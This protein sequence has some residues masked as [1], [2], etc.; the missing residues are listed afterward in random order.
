MRT[1]RLAAIAA[2]LLTIVACKPKEEAPLQVEPVSVT[3]EIAS[4][5]T[6]YLN[7]TYVGTIEE[8][9]S[10][11]VSF[12]GIGQVTRVC[13][14]EGQRVKKGQVIAEMDAAQ[15]KNMLATAEA[16]MAQ[17]NDALDRMKKLH[18]SGSLPDIKWVEVQ[19]QV[20][21]AKSQL[22]MAKKNVEDCRIYA[23]VSGI[24]S[25]KI[26]E[27]GMT[28]VTSQ[29]IVN[30]LDIS[31]VKVRVAIPE[32]EIAAIKADT[33]TIVSIEA[34]GR[35]MEGGHV[36]KCI[37]ADA[38]T[39]TYD[40]KITLPNGSGELLP[41]MIASVKIQG[42]SAK[43]VVSA[44]TLPVRCVQQS[45]DGSHFVW[46]EKGGKAHRQTVAIG[47]TYGN[48]IVITSGLNGGE[49]IITEGYQ[50]VG[51]GSAVKV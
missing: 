16:Q 20:A 30:I 31:S 44:I 4:S 3:T 15:A 38:T 24:I 2:S 22:D 29:P 34:I 45:S 48:R 43:D 46:I 17:A 19:S 42:S 13:V 36:E 1:I 12:T 11:P 18:D 14:Q 40:I 47:E 25:S 8:H 50:K 28:A 21:Q 5:S 6:D 23:P 37:T 49:R 27:D 51:E 33:R 7:K 26:V 9:S 39:H 10:T 41:G 35:S 32:K